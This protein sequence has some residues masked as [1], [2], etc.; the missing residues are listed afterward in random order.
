LALP[1]FESAFK[2]WHWWTTHSRVKA[3]RKAA[4][5]LKS[6]LYGIMNA[7]EYGVTNALAEGLNSNPVPLW[8]IR[9]D[10]Y[11]HNPTPKIC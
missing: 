8:K 3:V 11:I 7:V 9:L 5:T 10:A 2:K 1:D 4:K 6:H